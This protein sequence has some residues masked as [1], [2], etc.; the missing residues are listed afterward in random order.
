MV[1]EYVAVQRDLQTDL[2]KPDPIGMGS[3]NSDSHN[4]ERIIDADGFARNGRDV[5]VVHDSW[6]G[7]PGLRRGRR[8][9]KLVSFR[10]WIRRL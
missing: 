4:I 3:Y 5:Q 2:I 7:G 8:S 9:I 6:A 1:G 10:M